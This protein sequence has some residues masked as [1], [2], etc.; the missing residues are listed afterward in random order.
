MKGYID[1]CDANGK[2]RPGS[3]GMVGRSVATLLA[4]GWTVPEVKHAL[5][6]TRA[7]SVPAIEFV[8][9]AGREASTKGPSAKFERGMAELRRQDAVADDTTRRA[10]GDG[11]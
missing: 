3:P 4:S 10:V 11:R 9:N 8:L 5:T 7:Y 6:Q 2:A 1:W